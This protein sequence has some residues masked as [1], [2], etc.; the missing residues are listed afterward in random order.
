MHKVPMWAWIMCACIARLLTSEGL[1]ILNQW[2]NLR[3]GGLPGIRFQSI[4]LAYACVLLL[5]R[6]VCFTTD[7]R[8]LS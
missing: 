1:E 7:S 8:V 6:C 3:G 2:C 4:V 5:P